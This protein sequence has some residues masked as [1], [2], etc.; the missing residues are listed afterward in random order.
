MPEDL[1]EVAV[2]VGIGEDS[3]EFEKSKLPKTPRLRDPRPQTFILGGVKISNLPKLQAES[4]GD[5]IVHALCNALASAIGEG[6]LGTYATRLCALGKKNSFIY[7]QHILKKIERRHRRIVQCALNIEGS[8]PKI[9]PLAAR[10]KKNISR[11]L[12]IPANRIGITA[13]S[14][15]NLTPFG[16]GEG[17]RCQA[18]V[19]LEWSR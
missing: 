18:S 3:H 7:L 16:R 1:P 17:L 13:H 8:R 6:S 19:V 5:V 4:D 2:A 12:N 14:G 11:W 10:V 15:E 9:D